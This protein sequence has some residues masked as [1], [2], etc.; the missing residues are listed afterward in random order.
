MV[1]ADG[2]TIRMGAWAD[3]NAKEVSFCALRWK[4]KEISRG[5]VQDQALPQPLHLQQCGAAL[6][7]DPRFNRV[8]QLAA[9]S[10]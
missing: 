2:V 1:R 6:K 4:A 3:Q 8:T 10:Q 5:V 7:L 9:I